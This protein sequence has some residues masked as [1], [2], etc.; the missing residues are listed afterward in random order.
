MFEIKIKE[1]GELLE[2]KLR[3]EE[4]AK[5]WV[6]KWEEV[7]KKEGIY[8]IDYY[9]ITGEEDEREYICPTCNGSGEGQINEWNCWDCGGK[10]EKYISE[11]L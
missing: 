9:E 2:D 1:T 11:D 5:E 7:D 4:E 8:S 3:T 10:G 6:A